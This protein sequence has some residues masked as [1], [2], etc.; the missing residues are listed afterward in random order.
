MGPKPE[1]NIVLKRLIYAA[2]RLLINGPLTGIPLLPQ[3]N[4]DPEAEIQVLNKRTVE[5][6]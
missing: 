4:T 2:W 6:F 1:D 5:A 3:T